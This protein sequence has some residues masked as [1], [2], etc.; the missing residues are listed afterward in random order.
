MS[1]SRK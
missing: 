1:G